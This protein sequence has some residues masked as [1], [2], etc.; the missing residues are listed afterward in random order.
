MLYTLI[1][2]EI[3]FM[4][5]PFAAYYYALYAVPLNALAAH[6]ATAWLTQYALPHFSYSSSALVRVLGL[7]GWPLVLIGAG[8]FGAG[9]LQIYRAKFTG[10]GAVTAGLYRVIRHPQYTGLALVG[11]G[12]TLIW[13]RFIVL[14]AFAAMLC[15]YG[16]LAALEERLCERRFGASYRRY[17][18]QTGRFLPRR[19]EALLARAR[20][21]LPRNPLARAVTL[22]ALVTVGLAIALGTGILLRQHS[23]ASLELHRD[24]QRLLVDLAPLTSAEQQIVRVLLQDHWGNANLA[25]VAPESWQVPELGLVGA[26][27]YSHSGLDDLLSP[28]LHGNRVD[29]DTSHVQVLLVRA[30]HADPA[31]EWGATLDDVIGIEPQ[32]RLLLDLAAGE[33]RAEAPAGASQWQGIPT[34]VF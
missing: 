11:M 5:S 19:A 2:L 7:A 30:R 22:A 23:L 3:L 4:V 32:W 27:G 31:R 8:L 33:V 14:L 25:Y 24:G 21:C 18:D 28:G 29:A 6:P 26:T 20:W 10:G 13:S 9:F 17:A 12:T 15:L 34:P 1:V 16:A